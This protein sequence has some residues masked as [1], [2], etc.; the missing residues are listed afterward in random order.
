MKSFHRGMIGGWLT[1]GRTLAW[2]L[3]GNHSDLTRPSQGRGS[4]RPHISVLN[5]FVSIAMLLMI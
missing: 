5:H 3:L 2:S 1:T 4:L